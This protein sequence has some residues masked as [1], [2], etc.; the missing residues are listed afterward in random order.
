MIIRAMHD[1]CDGRGAQIVEVEVTDLTPEQITARKAARE[2][3]A[4][5]RA[6]VNAG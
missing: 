5:R 3:A 2:A 4:S 6:K 1:N